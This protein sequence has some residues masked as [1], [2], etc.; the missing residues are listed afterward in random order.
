[1]TR[2]DI[3]T[4]QG[5]R[6]QRYGDPL[7]L[8]VDIVCPGPVKGA[9]LTVTLVNR[10]GRLCAQAWLFDSGTP[11]CRSAGHHRLQCRFPRLRLAPGQ[12]AVRVSFADREDGTR[13]LLQ[14][15]CPFEV[16]VYG[17]TRE[18]G[19]PVNEIA[20]FE[21]AEWTAHELDAAD[22]EALANHAALSRE[23]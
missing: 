8:E 23:G 4:S 11:I 18:G 14:R 3:R 22:R 2:V 19:W 17:E 20:Y 16:V 21:D 10:L 15:V 5:G 12:Y 13:D 6:V 7:E 9:R 1:M